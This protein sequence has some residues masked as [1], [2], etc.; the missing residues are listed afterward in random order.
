MAVHPEHQRQGIGSR[1]VEAGSDRLADSGC[2]FIVVVGHPAFY[3]R[4]GFRPA[5]AYGITCEWGV[6]DDVFM[7][8]VL[9]EARMPRAGGM[10]R[11]RPEFSMVAGPAT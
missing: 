6:P 8:R 3:P 10:A 11:Y 2:P 7:V 5:S 4:F 1:L 9:D